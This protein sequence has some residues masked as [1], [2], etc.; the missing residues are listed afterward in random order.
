MRSLWR[1]PHRILVGIKSGII[2]RGI[3]GATRKIVLR[4]VDQAKG[5]AKLRE[6]LYIRVGEQA[7]IIGRKSNHQLC[8]VTHGSVVSFDKFTDGF[9]TRFVI[10]MPEPM[11]L[12]Q[13]S[14]GLGG[15]VP[16]VAAKV[17]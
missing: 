17:Q 7:T 9:Q 4:F 12:A 8:A 5:L 14:V 3:A 1:R 11:F 16:Q 10:G 13:R 6:A 2:S 15:T